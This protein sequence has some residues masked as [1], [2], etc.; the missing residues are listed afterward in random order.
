M[1]LSGY[2]CS[3]PEMVTREAPILSS[4]LMGLF[5]DYLVQVMSISDQL[6]HLE[7]FL[8]DEFNKDKKLLSDLYEL[9][10][11]AGNIVPRL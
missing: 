3:V 2:Q 1:P 4:A 9:V 10:Q 11:Y 7:Q 8:C 6:H 5:L